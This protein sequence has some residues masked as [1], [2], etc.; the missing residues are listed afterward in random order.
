MSTPLSWR[1]LRALCRKESLQIVRDPSSILI[2]FVLPIILLIIFGYGINLDASR[3]RIGVVSEDSGPDATRFVAALRASPVLETHVA[4]VRSELDHALAAAEVRGYVVL[5]SDFSARLARLDATAPVQVITD[6]SE[7]NTASFVAAYIQGVWS[8]WLA[9]RAADRG[10]SFAPP[11]EVIARS[12]FNPAALSRNFIVPGSIALIMT[13]IGALLTSLVIAREWERGTM[14]ALL[15]TA[16]TR[17]ELLLSKVLPYYALGMGSMLLCLAVAVW[18]FGVPFRGSLLLLLLYTTLFLG[19]TLGLGLLLSTVLRNQFNAAQAA[20]NAAFLPATM[21]SGFVFEIAS[22]PAPVRAVTYLI[23]ARY[24]ISALQT[25]FQAGFVG[26]ILLDDF[27]FLT[28]S[29]AFFL[30]LSALRTRRRLD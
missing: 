16:V 18:V 23:P 10:A 27:L 29:A 22:M 13:I 20:L 6:G 11:V 19:S 5:Q 28:A 1:R 9:G 2:A 17:T 4:S 12:W 7:P 15:S 8:S 21:L 25:L 26:R 30:G 24:F 14:E 3:I